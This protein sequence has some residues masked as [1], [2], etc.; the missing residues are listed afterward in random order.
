MSSLLWAQ[1]KFDVFGIVESKLYDN[2]LQSMM[3]I[4]FQG[5]MVVHNFL[6]NTMGQILVLWNPLK[7]DLSVISVIEQSIHVQITCLS[8]KTVF[9]A[10][11]VYG[12]NTIVQ[13]RA[14]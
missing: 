9:C 13:R 3:W 6:L 1:K 5:M 14:F 12:F 4:R 10:S 2:F 11:F 7:V 8:T